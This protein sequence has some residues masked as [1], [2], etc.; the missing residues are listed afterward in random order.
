MRKRLAIL[1]VI[2]IFLSTLIV[3]FHHHEDGTSND[4]CAICFVVHHSSS[5]V[6][7]RHDIQQI[8]DVVSYSPH[9]S[10]TLTDAVRIPG[11]SRSPPA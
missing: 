2:V 3:A 8:L 7:D 10:L 1:C 11:R 4:D 5:A 6:N 9:V